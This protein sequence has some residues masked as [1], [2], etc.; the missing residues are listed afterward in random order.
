VLALQLVRVG[1]K[2]VQLTVAVLVLG[3]HE[4]AR[5]DRVEVDDAG[6]VVDEEIASQLQAAVFPIAQQR[7]AVLDPPRSRGVARRGQAIAAAVRL[8]AL[9]P[10]S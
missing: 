9:P 8:Q 2:V 1:P 3:V 5:T 4:V 10:A 7:D 6:H